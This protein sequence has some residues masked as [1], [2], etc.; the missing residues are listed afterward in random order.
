ML[1]GKRVPS[2]SA[3]PPLG[4]GAGDARRPHPKPRAPEVQTSSGASFLR[5]GLHLQ[6]R[7]P[8][9]RSLK[10]PAAMPTHPPPPPAGQG[11]QVHP[12]SD[13]PATAASRTYQP[14]PPRRFGISVLNLFAMSRLFPLLTAEPTQPSAQPACGSLRPRAAPP[15]RRRRG[16]PGRQA[17]PAPPGCS[18]CL[19][20][21]APRWVGGG[22]KA[23]AAGGRRAG[24]LGDLPVSIAGP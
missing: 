7:R 16:E 6:P 19:W 11:A 10:L 2:L 22:R 12:C 17:W 14:L 15:H 8:P 18:C 5:L 13:P 21:D 23:G 9:G 3:P 24:Q 4:S 20:P 1:E